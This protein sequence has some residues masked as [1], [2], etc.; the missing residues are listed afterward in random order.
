[1]YVKT[2]ERNRNPKL[3][4]GDLVSV[5]YYKANE[6]NQEFQEWFKQN[7]DEGIGVKVTDYSDEDD[8]IYIENCPFAIPSWIVYKD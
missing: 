4:R 2:S 8:V 6:D 1:M 3:R 7:T 5:D